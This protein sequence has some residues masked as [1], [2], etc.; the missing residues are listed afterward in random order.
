MMAQFI[1]IKKTRGGGGGGLALTK[2]YFNCCNVV[3]GVC[4][5]CLQK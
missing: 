3:I 5:L 2:G 4:I 1:L